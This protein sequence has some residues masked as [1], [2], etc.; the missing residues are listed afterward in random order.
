MTSNRKA[1]SAEQ[2]TSAV[3]FHGEGPMWFDRLHWLDMLRGDILTLAPNG[4]ISRHH[5]GP[6]VAAVRPRARGGYV[7]ALDRCFALS[8]PEALHEQIVRLPAVLS[9]HTERFN[10]GGVDP[11]WPV[12]LRH[13]QHTRHPWPLRPVAARCR[14]HRRPRAV[15][16]HGVERPRL[17][18]GRHH[19]LLRRLRYRPH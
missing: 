16:N 8:G 18:P 17:V 4:D 14:S 15:R 1:R 7:Y 12:L 6:T 2:V 19:C 9:D 11:P 5:V 13:H 3:A 10:E